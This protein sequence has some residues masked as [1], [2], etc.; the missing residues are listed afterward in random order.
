M[1]AYE[2]MRDV[3][4]LPAHDEDPDPLRRREQVLAFVEKKR[5][6]GKTASNEDVWALH[7]AGMTLSAIDD[8]CGLRA[9]SARAIVSARWYDVGKRK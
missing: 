8:A 6:E 4:T 2:P 9:G 5:T 3:M 1:L 7:C